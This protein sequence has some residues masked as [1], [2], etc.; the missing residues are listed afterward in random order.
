MRHREQQLLGASSS[1]GRRRTIRYEFSA[2]SGL[3]SRNPQPQ[4][5]SIPSSQASTDRPPRTTTRN[6]PVA[7][8]NNRFLRPVTICALRPPMSQD[9]S[10]YIVLVRSLVARRIIIHLLYSLS[11]TPTTSVPSVSACPL[12]LPASCSP[13][14]V[15]LLSSSPC[16]SLCEQQCTNYLPAKHCLASE[17]IFLPPLLDMQLLTFLFFAR[18]QVW[19]CFAIAC[20]LD[21]SRRLSVPNEE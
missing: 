17:S 1:S 8:A 15:S 3:P 18:T 2:C 10:S 11:V 4:A 12:P 7:P 21:E 13:S 14:V 5:P 19:C 20:R 6:L 16:I 9:W